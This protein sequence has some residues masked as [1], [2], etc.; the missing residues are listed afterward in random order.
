MFGMKE[1]K[2]N[3][4]ITQTSVERPVKGCKTKVKKMTRR[5]LKSLGSY[6]E[7]GDAERIKDFE[8]YFCKEH[9]IYITPST[10]IYENLKDNLLWY[11]E[12]KDIFDAIMKVKRVKAQLYYDNS[13]D[14]VT[15]NVFRYLE[16]NKLLSGLLETFTNQLINPELIYWSYAQSEQDAWNKLVKARKEFGESPKRSS[17]PDL[18]VKSKNALIFIEAKFTANND[19]TPSNPN[20]LKQYLT[21]GNN[22]YD[23]VFKSDYQTVAISEKK[24]ELLRF[25]LIG[26]WIAEHLKLDFYLVNLVRKGYEEDIESKFGKHIR[27]NGR[28]KFVRISWEDVY[29]YISNSNIQN[30]DKPT[31]LGYFENKTVGYNKDGVLQ[32]AFQCPLPNP[33]PNQ[34]KLTHIHQTK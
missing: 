8:E 30:L 20:D 13:E 26:T 29:Q 32:K 24:Y 21:G 10:F 19:T 4:G 9:R 28:R 1:L 11:D 31:V 25:W 16:R 17:E 5:I 18:I 33:S 6:L 2:P 12:D 7:R 34:L 22:W 14:A 15:W 3:I 27:Q 23:E